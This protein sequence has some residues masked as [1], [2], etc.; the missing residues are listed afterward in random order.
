MLANQAREQEALMPP[1]FTM[2][3]SAG[4]D[5]VIH[6]KRSGMGCMNAFYVCWLVV[7]SGLCVVV[8]QLYLHGASMKKPPLLLVLMAWAFEAAG[9]WFTIYSLFSRKTYRTDATSLTVETVV[10]G[11]KRSKTIPKATI[12]RFIQVRDGGYRRGG[13]TVDSFPS[14]GLEVDAGK[15]IRLLLKQPYEKSRW[16]GQALARWAQVEFIEAPRA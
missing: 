2:A 12:K 9:L 11:F 5:F 7:W 6:H 8:L 3:P 4:E 13:R 16:L 15:N 10:L 1:G 14:W